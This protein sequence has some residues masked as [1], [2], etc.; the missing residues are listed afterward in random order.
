MRRLEVMRAYLERLLTDAEEYSLV[1]KLATDL[2]KQALFAKLSDQ[3][4]VMALEVELAIREQQQP[5]QKSSD[6]LS[7]LQIDRYR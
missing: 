2:Q 1:S 6:A 4:R 7:D 3:L 5:Q